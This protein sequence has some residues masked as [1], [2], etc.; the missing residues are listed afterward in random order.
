MILNLLSKL[1][2]KSHYVIS[3]ALVLLK[4]QP[5]LEVYLKDDKGHQFI[6]MDVREF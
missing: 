3:P 1:K 2:Y 4:F 5:D 6:M